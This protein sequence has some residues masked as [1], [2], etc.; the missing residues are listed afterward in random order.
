MKKQENSKLYTRRFIIDNNSLIILQSVQF[1]HIIRDSG[2]AER[3]KGSPEL[4]F[5]TFCTY[6]KNQGLHQLLL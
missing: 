5:S 6:L 1:H 4:T 3:W 2:A